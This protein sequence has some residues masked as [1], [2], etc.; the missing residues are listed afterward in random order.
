[1][2][3]R[4]SV[5]LYKFQVSLCQGMLQLFLYQCQV[6][7]CL[8]DS[9]NADD[10]SLFVFLSYNTLIFR[11]HWVVMNSIFHY[12]DPTKGDV[13]YNAIE[14]WLFPKPAIDLFL[15]GRTFEQQVTDIKNLA[16]KDDDIIVCAFAKC[17]IYLPSLY[18]RSL[19]MF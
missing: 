15:K 3:R 4:A 8:S 19:C 7:L 2:S 9:R 14:D 16:L 12:N 18:C 1:V 10:I 5:I 13:R 11:Y 17:G 6:S